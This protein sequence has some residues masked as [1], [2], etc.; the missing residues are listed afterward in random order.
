MK[1]IYRDYIQ[2]YQGFLYHISCPIFLSVELV[3]KKYNNDITMY[4]YLKNFNFYDRIIERNLFVKT[5]KSI[6]FCLVQKETKCN[7]DILDILRNI[8]FI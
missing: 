2:N 6:L 5:L 8:V 3:L 4:R 7:K 1:Y